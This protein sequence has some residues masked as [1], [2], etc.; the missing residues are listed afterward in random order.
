MGAI[1][2]AAGKCSAESAKRRTFGVLF[3]LK[4]ATMNVAAAQPDHFFFE[5]QGRN[6]SIAIQPV[7]PGKLASAEAGRTVQVVRAT[8]KIRK[9]LTDGFQPAV[10]LREAG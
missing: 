4:L 9:W 1:E 5:M 3:F 2:L 10:V 8:H 6:H 7:T